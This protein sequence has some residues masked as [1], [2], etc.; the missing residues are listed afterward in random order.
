MCIP[1]YRPPQPNLLLHGLRTVK[2][3]KVTGRII[4]LP[5]FPILKYCMD[6]FPVNTMIFHRMHAKPFSQHEFCQGPFTI[7]RCQRKRC[8]KIIT[9]VQP[10][11][12]CEECFPAYIRVYNILSR[13]HNMNELDV[14]HYDTNAL[15]IITLN[16]IS[17]PP[18]E[19]PDEERD[20]MLEP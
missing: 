10:I 8:K 1:I 7:E 11:I 9:E 3:L 12:D 16:F 2:C 20:N 15:D 18:T 4:N 13:R 6:C 5:S 14:L 19:N 17:P